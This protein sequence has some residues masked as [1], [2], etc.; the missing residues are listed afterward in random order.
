[1]NPNFGLTPINAAGG[2]RFTLTHAHIPGAMTNGAT[3]AEAI[4]DGHKDFITKV[5]EMLDMD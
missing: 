3:K 1:L 5:S 2:G 4:A